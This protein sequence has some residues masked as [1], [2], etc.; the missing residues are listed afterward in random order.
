MAKLYYK[1]HKKNIKITFFFTITQLFKQKKIINNEMKQPKDSFFISYV[2]IKKYIN[3]PIHK[4]Y[5][6]KNKKRLHFIIIY[7]F[8][9]INYIYVCVY[10]I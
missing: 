9:R 3:Y 1:Y 4:Y 7:N 2:E 8:V 5:F 6:I 10:P